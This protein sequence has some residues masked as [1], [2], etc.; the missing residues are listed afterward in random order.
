[1][2][3]SAVSSIGN[4]ASNVA[5]SVVNLVVNIVV[6]IACSV[7]DAVTGG[8][9]TEMKNFLTNIVGDI[10]GCTIAWDDAITSA[11]LQWDAA[12]IEAWWERVLACV[13]Q[14]AQTV[15]PFGV[16]VR[17][18]EYPHNG[19]FQG[20]SGSSPH[21]SKA[22][23]SGVFGTGRNNGEYIINEDGSLGRMRWNPTEFSYGGVTKSSCLTTKQKDTREKAMWLTATYAAQATNRDSQ[24]KSASF[25]EWM[26]DGQWWERNVVSWNFNLP[27]YGD[28]TLGIIEPCSAQAGLDFD[29]LMCDDGR[30]DTYTLNIASHADDRYFGDQFTMLAW[31]NLVFHGSGC[32]N[33]FGGPV[34]TGPMS[35]MFLYLLGSMDASHS[36]PATWTHPGINNGNGYPFSHIKRDMELFFQTMNAVKH[37]GAQGAYTDTSGH[38]PSN[39]GWL[40]NMNRLDA[41]AGNYLDA[42]PL[43]AK[44][45]LGMCLPNCPGLIHSLDAQLGQNLCGK[46]DNA[47]YKGIKDNIGALSIAGA[48]PGDIWGAYPVG[49]NRL[50]YNFEGCKLLITGAIHFANAFLVQND[51]PSN[52]L[53]LAGSNRPALDATCDQQYHSRWHWRA[54]QVM[55][56]FM[57]MVQVS[58]STGTTPFKGDQT[59]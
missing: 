5:E 58:R 33:S 29:F 10:A 41:L 54:T 43:F 48:K 36:S 24:P 59:L 7:G 53:P 2:V 38:G 4:F 37:N 27:N 44:R 42:I 11:I 14:Q 12:P 13:Q 22:P 56:S 17:N 50:A 30:V 19:K 52:S 21:S 20:Q 35:Y 47:V 9:C 18:E 32:A 40:Q 3:S 8:A 31:G 46:Y 23:T 1:M 6:D 34:D 45:A 26:C 49:A 51:N 25:N 57:W 28:Q 55:R 15:Y 39:Q 16:A